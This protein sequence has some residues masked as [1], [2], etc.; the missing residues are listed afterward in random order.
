MFHDKIDKAVDYVRKQ[1]VE[2]SL[3]V[4]DS[5]VPHTGQVPTVVTRQDTDS[6]DQ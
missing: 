6:N 5:V 1:S 4:P 2:D 3:S